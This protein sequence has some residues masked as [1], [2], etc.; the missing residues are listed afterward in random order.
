MLAAIIM[1][2]IIIIRFR[3]NSSHPSC[4]SRIRCWGLQRVTVGKNV[5]PEPPPSQGPHFPLHPGP[6]SPSPASCGRQAVKL[7]PSGL[8]EGRV[9][10][11]QPLS[12]RKSAPGTQA[13]KGTR[14]GA[15]HPTGPRMWQH[16]KFCEMSLNFEEIRRRRKMARAVASP[17][18]FFSPP[19]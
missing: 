10:K 13:G 18:F 4:R 3:V 19:R 8:D 11:E 14:Y 16:D 5:C 9:G 17:S 7:F 1:I 6:P 2:T 15:P 12:S